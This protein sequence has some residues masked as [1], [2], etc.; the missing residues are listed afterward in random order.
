MIHSGNVAA[1]RSTPCLS[2]PFE[3]PGIFT[4]NAPR[5]DHSTSKGPE[6]HDNFF[7]ERP[8]FLQPYRARTA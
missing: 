7:I 3:L 6:S 4:A 1:T 5:P 8:N 2:Q